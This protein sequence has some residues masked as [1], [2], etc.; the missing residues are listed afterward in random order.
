MP[1]YPLAYRVVALILLAGCS[2]TPIMMK[3]PDG[4]RGQCGP[5]PTW[6]IVTQIH[7]PER[8]RD[9]VYQYVQSGYERAPR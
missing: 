8:E 9:C 1:R 4:R 3:H 2:S 7:L 6:G 5:Y